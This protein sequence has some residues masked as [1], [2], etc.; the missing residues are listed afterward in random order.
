MSGR[1]DELKASLLARASEV[2]KERREQQKDE[3]RGN[4]AKQKS[5]LRRCASSACVAL[6]RKNR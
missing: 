1:L 4:V 5:E 3:I 6:A 2:E